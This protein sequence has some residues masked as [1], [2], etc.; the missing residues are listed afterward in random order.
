MRNYQN[1]HNTSGI[2][3][4]ETLIILGIIGVLG[5]IL[6]PVFLPQHSR[7][8]PTVCLSNIKRIGLGI[9][10]YQEDNKGYYPDFKG[11]NELVAKQMGWQ[12]ILSCPNVYRERDVDKLPTY[13]VNVSLRGK[14]GSDVPWPD[15]TLLVFDSMP[16]RNMA[17]DAGLLPAVPRHYGGNIFGFVDGHAKW[18]KMKGRELGSSVPRW[19]P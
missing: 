11:W 14:R 7:K 12:D 8:R 13:A 10:M 4:W 15:Q 2:T 1:P 9:L 16:G 18:Y 19:K 6:Y 5:L 17:G 3:I